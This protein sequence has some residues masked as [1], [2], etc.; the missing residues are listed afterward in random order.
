MKKNEMKEEELEQVNGGNTIEKKCCKSL[1]GRNKCRRKRRY[2]GCCS[3]G[4]M[5]MK[6]FF[7][8]W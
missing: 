7:L 5:E 8:S 3:F 6:A 4:I 1:N 2:Y